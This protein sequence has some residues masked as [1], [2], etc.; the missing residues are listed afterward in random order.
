V[1]DQTYDQL[2]EQI[3]AE[4]ARLQRAKRWLDTTA[5]KMMDDFGPVKPYVQLLIQPILD[6]LNRYVRYTADLYETFS[7]IEWDFVDIANHDS[8]IWKQVRQA[9]LGV[10]HRVTRF[11]EDKERVTSQAQADAKAH[12]PGWPV[13]PSDPNA[14]SPWS[15]LAGTAYSAQIMPQATAAQFVADLAQDT[16][17]FLRQ[18]GENFG[19][20]I[21][22]LTTLMQQVVLFWIM[23]AAGI[24]ELVV[25][26]RAA[27]TPAG[28]A[29]IAWALWTFAVAMVQR[30]M[31]VNPAVIAYQNAQQIFRNNANR[32]MQD[33]NVRLS[34]A[35][36]VFH[37][38]AANSEHW[39]DPTLLAWYPHV[40]GDSSSGYRVTTGG[41]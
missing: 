22:L 4:Y 40:V 13:P 30:L 41:N 9:A 39:P 20:V 7:Q 11:S 33:I 2:R 12:N 34:A 14:H 35:P 19:S 17:E 32:R 25:G 28:Q 23:F 36:D 37:Y 8:D 24:I 6:A 29:T 27:M 31:L 21:A 38:R 18:T 26:L 10:V 1:T 3:R 16:S 15:G 5:P